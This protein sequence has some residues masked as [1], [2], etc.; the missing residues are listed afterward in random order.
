MIDLDDIVAKPGMVPRRDQVPADHSVYSHYHR[1]IG[2]SPDLTRVMALPTRPQLDPGSDRAIALV[3]LIQRR[4]SRDRTTPCQ[5]REIAPSRFVDGN[6]GCITRVTPIQAWALFEIGLHGGLLG[7]IGVGFGKTLIDILA[8]LALADRWD[9]IETTG[10]RKSYSVLL[11]V[12]PKLI[13]QLEREYRLI[14]EHFIVPEIVFHTARPIHYAVADQPLLRVLPYTKLSTKSATSFLSNTRPKAIIA[15]EAHLLKDPNAVRTSRALRYTDSDESIRWV[16]LTGS[17]TDRSIKDYWHLAY[18]ALRDGSP[19]PIDPIVVAEWASSVDAVRVRADGSY[20]DNADPGALLDGLISTGI[21]QPGESFSDGLSKRLTQTPGVIMTSTP[22]IDTALEIS[23]RKVT[24]PNT[25]KVDDR[26]DCGAW[27]GLVD[28]LKMV[29]DGTR[30]DGEEICDPLLKHRCL[31]EL[32]SGFFY[33]WIFPRGE[34]E[35]LIAEWRNARKLW[36]C[37]VRDQ[38]QNRREFLDSPELCRL[39]AQRY[40]G[41]LPETMTVEYYDSDGEKHTRA[42][43]DLPRWRSQHWQRW[44][45]VKD[46]VSPDTSAVWVDDFL[47]DDAASWA[48]SQRGVVWYNQDAFGKRLAKRSGLPI[49]G[50]GKNA[51]EKMLGGFVDGKQIQGERGDRSIIVSIKAHGTGTDGL[52]RLFSRQLIANPLASNKDTEQLLGRLHRVGQH[53]DRVYAEVYR[54]T[55]EIRRVFAQSLSRAKYCQEHTGSV[56][57]LNIGWSDSEE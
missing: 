38:L 11:L 10:D 9:R 55:Q 51:S 17:I 35:D 40:Y 12:P 48:H 16:T 2:K 15:D 41:E 32:A 37:E 33:R 46:K 13:P 30:P 44:A 21:V 54:H 56:Q 19:L 50:G 28:C 5:C 20:E 23:E 14:G 57:K 49:Y 25:P 45:S 1:A 18:Y 6:N 42:M 8:P 7:G 47:V 29:R 31:L 52:Q 34:P 3:E 36:H 43:D 27:P 53:A 24:L 26:A 39:A 4:Y 22:A